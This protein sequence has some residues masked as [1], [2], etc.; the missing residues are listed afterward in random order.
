M[1][2][3]GTDIGQYRYSQVPFAD[4]VRKYTF[5]SLDN[6]TSKTG[7]RITKH[8][9]IPTEE[10]LKAMD[11]FVDAMDLMSAGDENEEGYV[12]QVWHFTLY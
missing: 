1:F 8:P 11:S 10:Q 2:P 12:F 6:F 4:D 9:H 7:E 5:R 3:C